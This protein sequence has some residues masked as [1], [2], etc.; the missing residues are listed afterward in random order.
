MHEADA[1]SAAEGYNPELS[2][3]SDKDTALGASLSGNNAEIAEKWAHCE[4]DAFNCGKT[5]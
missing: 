3:T 5:L 4:R 2:E 1:P